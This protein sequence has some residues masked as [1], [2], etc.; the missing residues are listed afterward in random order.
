MRASPCD[1]VNTGCLSVGSVV[2]FRPTDSHA[3]SFRYSSNQR[4]SGPSGSRSEMCP[5]TVPCCSGGLY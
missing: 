4:S 5:P 2:Q 1:T 3:F